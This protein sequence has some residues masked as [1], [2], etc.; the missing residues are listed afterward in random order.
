MSNIHL[1]TVINASAERCFD[2]SRSI[3]LHMQS[4]AKTGE[5]AVAG[6]TLG[7]A[8]Y[9]DTITWEATHFGIRQ[10]LTTKITAMERPRYFVDEMLKG[11]F[12]SIHHKHT[13][14]YQAGATIMTD[15]FHYE[16]PFWILGWLFDVLVLKKYMT[17]FL[18]E[19][20][21]LI[22]EIAEN[23]PANAGV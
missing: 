4:T 18:L 3:E 6:R 10:Q 15:D 13:F 12:K 14:E 9:G 11:A 5:R 8:E 22:K 21:S 19:R 1:V 17:G 7:L 2:L 16:T 23:I 20:N